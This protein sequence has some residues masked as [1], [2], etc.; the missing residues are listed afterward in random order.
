MF[1]LLLGACGTAP[2]K[3]AQNEEATNEV[4]PEVTHE[5]VAD[6]PL[7]ADTLYALLV[8]ELAMGRQRHDIA[9]NNYVQQARATLDPGV[10]EHATH[11]ARM[12]RAS[13]D[14]LSMA[15]LWSTVE[16]EN[17]EARHLYASSLVQANRFDEAF[18][19][20]R[21]LVESGETAAFEDLAANAADGGP[22]LSQN[23]A[24]KYKE[25]LETYP[26][27]TSLLVGYSLLLEQLNQTSESLKV[28]R[29]ALSIDKNSIAALY[30]ESRLLLALGEDKLAMEKM[31]ELVETNPG[32][33]RLRLRY[34]RA[35]TT[36]HSLSRQ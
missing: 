10:A 30:Q 4:A 11:L 3:T 1:C 28:V 26:D 25:L 6:K 36:A 5:R 7:S 34:A 12:L 32:N 35:L 17:V 16:P 23:L 19:Q 27:N 9:L 13:D 18:E 21:L 14:A 33:H 15:E 2:V 20:A 31:G 8:A 22:Q 24:V 29:H